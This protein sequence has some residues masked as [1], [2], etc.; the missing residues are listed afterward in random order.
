MNLQALNRYYDRLVEAGTLER[1]GWQPV[2]VSYAL[3]I[4][5]AG[6]LLRVLP[7]IH[8]EERGKKNVMVPQ[9]MN[10]PAQEK[11]AVGIVSN[12]LCDN[13]SYILGIDA[14]GKPER[15]IKCFQ[16]CRELH[17]EIL[18]PLDSMPGHAVVRFFQ[19]WNPHRASEVDALVPYLEDI[20]KGANLVF[21]Y[22]NRFV[23]EYPEIQEVW[24]KR[25][26]SS[27]ETVKMRCLVTGEES[28]F[29]RLHPTIKGVNGGQSSG[30]SLV[31]FNA[32]AFES[33]GRDGGQGSNAPVSEK[34]AFAYGAAL[35][36]MIAEIGHHI[37]LS[38]TTIVFW[39]EHGEDGYAL[40]FSGMM[41]EDTGL[42][43]DDLF[44][45]LNHL[46]NGR[47]AFL[48]NYELNPEEHFYILGLAPNAARLSV[49]FFLQDSFGVFARN[50][51]K[52]HERLEIIKPVYD[53]RIS[54][55]FWHIMNE[56]VNQ[57]SRDKTPSPLLT[58]S[59]IRSVLMNQPYPR[60]LLDQV[61]I[62]IRAEREVNR[63]RAAIIKAYL[64]KE[65]E[66]GNL[67]R[68]SKEALSVELNNET[69]YQP[70]LLGRLFAVLEGLQLAANPG[71]NSTIRDRYF[72]SACATPSVIF[73][74]LIKLAQAHLKKVGGGLEKTYNAKIG[75]IMEKIGESYPARLNLYDQGIFQLGYYHQSQARYVKK[76]ENK[77]A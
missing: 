53:N 77:N 61:E 71:I 70:Y 68:F 54:L 55:S 20:L 37:R 2:K 62:R 11:R 73:P 52:H 46:A 45:A 25:Y 17:E 38:D 16:A 9:I 3:Q 60:L 74:Q 34:A 40:Q 7:L 6:Q 14:K 36:Y 35:N 51:L 4:D 18:G 29:A 26:G 10:V 43:E 12:F 30:T 59:L 67:S 49:R 15:S 8:E 44:T 28:T 64:L 50:L 48:N 66:N 21:D 56:T 27:N 58:G 33:F 19:N 69:T 63:G 41:G 42:S 23:Q 32:P 57:K 1:I 75:S 39:A 22:R 13:S 76:E 47:N 72:N 24:D 65:S 31:S 5:D